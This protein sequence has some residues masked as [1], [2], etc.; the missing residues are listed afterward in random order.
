MPI[1]K[2]TNF[3]EVIAQINADN[4]NLPW[5]ID[6]ENF[7]Y[8][9]P[10]ALTTPVGRLNTSIK[11]TAKDSSKY[12]GMVEVQYHRRVLGD[13]FRGQ[14]VQF[15]RWINDGTNMTKAASIDILNQ[16]YGINLEDATISGSGWAVPTDGAIRTWTATA[17][18]YAYTGSF[19]VKWN[20]GLQQIGLDILTVQELNGALWPDG[21]DFEANPDRKFDGRFLLAGLDCTEFALAN[22]WSATVPAA[23]SNGSSAAM[24]ALFAWINQKTGLNFN[25]AAYDPVTNPLGGMA[26]YLSVAPVA[27][28]AAASNPL[29]THYIKP[30]FAYAAAIDLRNHPLVKAIV[31]LYFNI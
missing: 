7:L 4:P 5:P 20:R 9:P 14:T 6:A 1:F 21:N 25:T 27:L 13:L 10:T 15:T 30:G 3:N 11:I 31:P 17:G 23:G 8:G 19:S 18:N 16:M 24:T 29:R 26:S 12:R 22:G 28:P 2:G